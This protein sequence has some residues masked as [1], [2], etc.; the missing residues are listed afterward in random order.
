MWPGV[1][2]A[3]AF[4]W[5]GPIH[6]PASRGPCD[7]W[8][9]KAKQ[10]PVCLSLVCNLIRQ[11]AKSTNRCNAKR[12]SCNFSEETR[13]LGRARVP[14]HA[15]FYI[16]V[17]LFSPQTV[18]RA[19]PTCIMHAQLH[20]HFLGDCHCQDKSFFSPPPLLTMLGAGG[21]FSTPLQ[22]QFFLYEPLHI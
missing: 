15:C 20:R 1:K 16:P 22:H 18:I 5:A 21:A 3:A 12:N 13:G 6:H 7:S 17:V 4:R 8:P 19:R 10:F 11:Q 14:G 2:I 9:L